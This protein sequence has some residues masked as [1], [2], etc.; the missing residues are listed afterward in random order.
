MASH[1][2]QFA[3]L[4]F[5][6]SPFLAIWETT[7]ACPLA[8]RHCRAEAVVDRH[9][10]ELTT[11]EGKDLLNQ[12]R[13]MGTPVCVLSGGD[14]LKRPDLA[15]LIH[16][17]HGLGLRMATIPAASGDLTREKLAALKE[18][19]LA[20]VA[21]SLD[22]PTADI[23]DEFRQVEGT[24]A[25]TM[26]AIDWA[27]ELKLPVQIN[28]TFSRYN[29]ND[30][31]AMITLVRGAGVVFWEVFS[32]VPTGRGSAL[33]ALTADEHEVLFAK[34]Y[35]LSKQ[36]RFIIKVTE[37]PHFRRYILQQ[38]AA[39]GFSAEDAPSTGSAIPAQLS[40]D[41][42][43]SDS[44]GAAA[45]GI[46][47]GKGFCFI[48]HTGEVFP[49]GFLPLSVGNVR[50]HPLAMLYR[51]SDLFNQLRDSTRLEGRCGICEFADVCGGSRA[52]A[53]AVTG[54]YKAEDPACAYPLVPAQQAVGSSAH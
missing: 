28:T 24:F 33:E 42:S 3:S 26:Q 46:N 51:D 5:A 41:M 37:A 49:S 54:N 2:L 20:Q 35:A 10:D 27:H 23:H 31:D 11:T 53:Y 50:Q 22:G 30:I 36:V 34:L 8:C 38:R 19:G 40:R 13:A 18:A 15:E 14:P 9:P 48:S 45:K 44:F 16:Y 7:Q 1:A 43:T 52:R 47:A 29:R 6:K 4:D 17:G 39:D 21:F 32:L 25:K 12:I